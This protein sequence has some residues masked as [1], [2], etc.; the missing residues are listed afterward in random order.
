MEAPSNREHDFSDP[1]SRILYSPIVTRPPI[2]WPNN[3]RVAFWV[4]PN[5]EHY[6]YT[7][8]A[9]QAF[10]HFP[11][12]PVPDVQQY[13]L[14]DYGNRV[15]FWRMTTVLDEFQIRPTVSLNLAVLDHY[16]EIRDAM[17][18][19]DWSF[20]SHGIYNTRV[21]YEYSEDEE[22]EFLR[23]SVESLKRHTGKELKG[24]L[25]PALSATIRT[26]DLMLDAGFTYHADWPLDD[27]P[28][29][30]LTQRG[31]LVSVPYSYDHNDGNPALGFNLETWASQ[32]I[33]QFDRLW[34]EGKDSGRV[35]CIA[36]HPFAIGQPQM[37]DYLRHV[38]EHVAAHENVWHTTADEI[39]EYYL[40]NCYDEHIQ[41]AEAYLQKGKT[42]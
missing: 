33:A 22:R 28:V 24:M 15:G 11:R 39:A 38:L 14:R 40:E 13:G 8:P 12:V 1:R 9:N 7:P 17:V 3:C 10:N 20:M 19:R 23:N 30:V 25:G 16:P 31:R 27:Q 4:S 42:I 2:R 34:R 35:M 29:P 32:C 41:H 26:P 6:E 21:V 5:V 36:L 18:E 37:I